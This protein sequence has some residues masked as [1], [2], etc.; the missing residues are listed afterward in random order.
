MGVEVGPA[1][2]A[3]MV[4]GVGAV[5]AVGAMVGAT[6]AA[7]RQLTNRRAARVIP[8][9]GCLCLFIDRYQVR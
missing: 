4:S 6:C 2:A 9:R 1:A 7:G 5:V 3:G 8:L